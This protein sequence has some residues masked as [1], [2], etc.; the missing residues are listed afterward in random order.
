MID[1]ERTITQLERQLA[2]CQREN[3]EIRAEFG[4]VMDNLQAAA[5]EFDDGSHAGNNLDET[6]VEMLRDAKAENARLVNE[7]RQLIAYLNF[8]QDKAKLALSPAGVIQM[9]ERIL[10]GGAK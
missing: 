8:H 4:E 5:D 7:T 9:L 1:T 2:E 6:I 10:S 3:A